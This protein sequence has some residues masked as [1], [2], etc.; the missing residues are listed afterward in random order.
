LLGVDELGDV[1]VGAD[2]VGRLQ[3]GHFGVDELR[4]LLACECHA[5]VAVLDE[6]RPADLEDADGGHDAIGECRAQGRQPAA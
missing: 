4:A 3:P 2:F 5:V 6:V 1:D